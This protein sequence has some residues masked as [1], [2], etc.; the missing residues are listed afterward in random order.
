MKP[1]DTIIILP[2]IA[3]TN[4]RLDALIGQTATIT[5]VN[6]N[7][8]IIKGCWVQLPGFYLGEREWYIPYNSIGI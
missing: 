2:S 3:L 1:G 5:E 4:L 7:A 6:V 8:D